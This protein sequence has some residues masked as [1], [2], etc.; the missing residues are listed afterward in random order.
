MVP[1]LLDGLNQIW[2]N[3]AATVILGVWSW[4]LHSRYFSKVA[5]VV[6]ET[7]AHSVESPNTPVTETTVQPPPQA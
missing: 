5:T 7:I 1:A 4:A 3:I 6:E 2:P